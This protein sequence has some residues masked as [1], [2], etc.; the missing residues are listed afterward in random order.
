MLFI[1]IYNKHKIKKHKVIIS[2]TINKNLL[3]MLNKSKIIKEKNKMI[4]KKEIKL[5]KIIILEENLI[6]IS[7]I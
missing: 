3:T 7:I 5:I 2:L 1:K 4:I 6:I